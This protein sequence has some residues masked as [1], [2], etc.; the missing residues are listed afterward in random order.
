MNVDNNLNNINQTNHREKTNSELS[1]DYQKELVANI[2]AKARQE[3]PQDGIGIIKFEPVSVEYKDLK[4]E[5]VYSLTVLT[6]Y[7]KKIPEQRALRASYK[8]SDKD[9][10]FYY[11]NIKRGTKQEILDYLGDERNLGEIKG[12][13]STLKE[14]ALQGD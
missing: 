5:D 13:L 2:Y 6:G 7:N 1:K 4:T 11:M 3:V 10:S 8:L 9:S 12:Y 14:R